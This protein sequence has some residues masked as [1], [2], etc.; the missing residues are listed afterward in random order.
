MW[1]KEQ[2]L[3]AV[4]YVAW[5]DEVV[6]ALLGVVTALSACDNRSQAKAEE[7]KQ[8]EAAKIAEADREAAQKKAEAQQEL[9]KTEAKLASDRK[10]ARADLQKTVAAA[11]RKAMDL[12]E[13]AA[14]VKGKAKLNA[15][16]SPHDRAAAWLWGLPEVKHREN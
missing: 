6:G 10:E 13:R 2:A 15:E 8:T 14:K 1:L 7:A 3:F 16:G 12:K 4:R 5:L 9:A 11:D